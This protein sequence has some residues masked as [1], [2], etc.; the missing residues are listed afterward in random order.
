MRD[1]QSLWSR[2]CNAADVSVMLRSVYGS[3]RSQSASH[4]VS[5]T[6]KTAGNTKVWWRDGGGA[7]DNGAGSAAWHSHCGNNCSAST[8]LITNLRQNL[9]TPPGQKAKTPSE[10]TCAWTR[11]HN[12]RTGWG[13]RLHGW[14]YPGGILTKKTKHCQMKEATHESIIYLWQ[15]RIWNFIPKL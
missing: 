9:E 4:M 5:M 7:S 1:E 6:K 3:I 13:H 14:C 15:V 8:K 12:A 10:K 2:R 11:L